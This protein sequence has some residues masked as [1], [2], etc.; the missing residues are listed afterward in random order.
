MNVTAL[1]VK[2]GKNGN[3][4]NEMVLVT[5]SEAGDRQLIDRGPTW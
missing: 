1:G 5:L 4:A 2:E 3:G